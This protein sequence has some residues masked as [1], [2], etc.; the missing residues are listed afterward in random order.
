MAR[1]RIKKSPGN[2][3]IPNQTAP[4]F[5][6][7]AMQKPA[8][9]TGRTLK[10]VPRD[11]ANIEAEAGETALMPNKNGLPAHFNIHGNR[12]TSGGTPLNVP[13]DTFIF[14]D[15]KK[16][17]IKDPEI[18]A[19]FGKAKG[20]W[21]PADLAKKYDINKYRKLLQ[22]PDSDK[23]QVKTAEKMIENYNLKLAKLALVQES[24]KGFP[25]G[26]PA[27]AM[28][29]L[30]TYNVE[31]DQILPLKQP[32]QEALPQMRFGG[33]LPRAQEGKTLPTG[34]D[35]SRVPDY[36]NAWNAVDRDMPDAATRK[37]FAHGYDP[38]YS[39]WDF[40]ME[41]TRG[42]SQLAALGL[43]K[44]TGEKPYYELYPERTDR[45]EYETLGKYIGD[46]DFTGSK[47]LGVTADVLLDPLTYVPVGKGIKWSGQ[48]A[49]AAWEG[50]SHYGPE[51]Y[52]A[53]KRFGPKAYEYMAKA[54]PAAKE[55][56]LKIAANPSLSAEMLT[57]I[58]LQAGRHSSEQQDKFSPYKT[59][60]ELPGPA[61]MF[62]PLMGMPNVGAD[63]EA[64][65]DTIPVRIKSVPKPSTLPVYT[66]PAVSDSSQPLE[67]DIQDL[68]KA[69]GIT[70]KEAVY[71]LTGK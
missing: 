14:S 2:S 8:F 40:L 67:D 60:P 1:I 46:K 32:E 11:Q 25:Q 29:F 35:W 48:A 30:A 65:A 22:D 62:S 61:N 26:I 21:T 9:N 45:G 70:R 5:D 24:K 54:Y 27:V 7:S 52:Q 57:K 51:L 3:A 66:Q 16:M 55:A 47:V 44:L 10:A 50:V 71:V 56:F 43:R 41:M 69:E 28:P 38:N 4:G 12:H 59:S 33:S 34:M 15:T 68:M 31:P 64:A 49:K 13:K 63:Y 18:L 6:A 42:P 20:S 39:G 19:E 17:R 23:L 36:S 53:L 37:A 58:I